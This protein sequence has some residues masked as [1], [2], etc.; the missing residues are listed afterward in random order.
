MTPARCCSR[1]S[2]WRSARKY[3]RTRRYRQRTSV[4][5]RGRLLR[6]ASRPRT[7]VWWESPPTARSLEPP[8]HRQ[9]QRQALPPPTTSL[10]R[11]P[12][13]FRL[14]FPQ[15]F[16][17]R[18]TVDLLAPDLQHHRDGE[19]RD[20]VE[21]FMD[22]SALDA[23]EHLAEAADV[24][25]AGGGV[26]ARGAQEDVVG[27]VLAQHVVDEVGRDRYLAARFLL[28]REAALDQ[29]GDDCASAERTLHQRGFVEPGF[30]VVA[31]HVLAEQ[32]RERELAAFDAQ[33]DVAEP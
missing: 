23:R 22:D 33:R 25:E 14:G 24:E 31:Q 9:G 8:K 5:C 13:Q 2:R 11:L 1:L 15:H 26:G 7:S 6:S 20:V 29:P 30:E 16:L 4:P 21:G 32:G 28:P 17:G 3:R 27:L 19:R 18:L 10:H 12:H